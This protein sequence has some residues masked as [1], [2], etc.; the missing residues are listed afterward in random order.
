MYVQCT[1]RERKTDKVEKLITVLKTG[2]Y[3]M[4][5]ALYVISDSNSM[6]K[7]CNIDW[8]WCCRVYHHSG[9]VK[10]KVKS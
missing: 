4:W 6:N 10:Q 2:V 3:K 8:C 9:I 1:Y 5:N 7:S